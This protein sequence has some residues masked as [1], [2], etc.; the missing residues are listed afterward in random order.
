MKI[1]RIL[2][3]SIA[4]GI[5]EYHLRRIESQLDYHRSIVMNLD[6]QVRETYDELRELREK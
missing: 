5:L 4:I 1:T 3:K 6:D 2:P